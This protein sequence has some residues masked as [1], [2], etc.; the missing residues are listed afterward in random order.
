MW[1]TLLW[2]SVLPA[3]SS[4]KKGFHTDKWLPWADLG[5]MEERHGAGVQ[6]EQEEINAD[7]RPDYFSTGLMS[8]LTLRG[9]GDPFRGFHRTKLFL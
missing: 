7:H 9:L 1:Q 5:F 4:V 8:N 6:P 3:Q 2:L